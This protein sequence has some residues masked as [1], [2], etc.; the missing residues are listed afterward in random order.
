MNYLKRYWLEI[1]VAAIFIIISLV[2]SIIKGDE[3]LA[4]IDMLV[5][6]TQIIIVEIK[7]QGRRTSELLEEITKKGRL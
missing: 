4:S 5:V 2:E 3:I 1:I 6:W 7:E